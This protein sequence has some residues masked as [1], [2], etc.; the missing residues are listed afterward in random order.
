MTQHKR[1]RSRLWWRA[2]VWGERS[3]G[4]HAAHAEWPTVDG[5]ACHAGDASETTPHPIAA[6]SIVG[7]SLW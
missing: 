7:C 5:G 3:G 1:T 6:L 2:A 4:A